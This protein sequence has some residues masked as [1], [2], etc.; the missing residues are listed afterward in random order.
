MKTLILGGNGQLGRALLDTATGDAK[1]VSLDLPE[2]D[3]ADTDA[4]CTRA[5]QL[6]PAVIINAAAYTAVD[7]AETDVELAT[8]VNVDGA[9]NA[10]IA[11]SKIGARFIHVSTDFVFDGEAS[12]PYRPD[13]ATSPLSVYG[14]T[15][16]D[17]ELA[18]L[19]ALPE[20]SVIVRTA[21]LY[22]KTGSNYVKTMLRLMA[23]RDELRVVA[24]QTGSPTWANSLASAIWAL[25]DKPGITG[26]FHWTDGGQTNWHGFAEAIQ[27]EALALGLLQRKVPVL[28]ITSDEYPT[29]A[30]RPAYSVLDCSGTCAAAGIEQT[31]WRSNLRTML[32]GMVS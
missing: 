13:A 30:R 14:R 20:A 22:S 27:E 12:T 24:D 9:R 3:I 6:Q 4:I 19:E 32:Q 5:A 16:R 1:I 31:D 17:G 23:E 29:D 11:A 28:A 18:V 8:A 26:I 2:L 21:W 25:I 7:R 10:A 15:K